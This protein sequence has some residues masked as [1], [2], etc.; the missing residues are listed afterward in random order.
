MDSISSASWQALNLLWSGNAELWEIVGISFK[1][2]GVAILIAAPLAL[3][4]ACVLALLWMTQRIFDLN[5]I[6]G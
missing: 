4:V 2:S 6:P 3:L 5:W 1:V